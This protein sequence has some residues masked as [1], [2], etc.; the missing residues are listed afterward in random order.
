MERAQNSMKYLEQKFKIFSSMNTQACSCLLIDA[1]WPKHFKTEKIFGEILFRSESKELRSIESKI[2]TQS[3]TQTAQV[4]LFAIPQQA[5]HTQYEQRTCIKS[6]STLQSIP[7]SSSSSSHMYMCYVFYPFFSNAHIHTHC[8]VLAPPL[9]F[10]KPTEYRV[11][12]K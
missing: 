1:D 12:K 4:R 6:H 11:Y 7:P 3:F 9:N 2:K 10:L 8:N 5:N